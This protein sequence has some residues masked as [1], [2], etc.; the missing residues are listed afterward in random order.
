MREKITKHSKSSVP[1]HSPCFSLSS[2]KPTAPFF[3]AHPGQLLLDLGSSGSQ[4]LY[5]A[6]LFRNISNKALPLRETLRLYRKGAIAFI[7][8]LIHLCHK[9]KTKIFVDAKQKILL[10][11]VLSQLTWSL[12][13]FRQLQKSILGILGC[14]LNDLIDL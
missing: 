11:T 10:L 7:A 8:S 3:R 5:L 1:C 2:F 9:H 4:F 14:D 13:N 6:C 12:I